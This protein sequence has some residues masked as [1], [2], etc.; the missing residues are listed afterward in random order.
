MSP[1][2]IKTELLVKPGQPSPNIR[3]SDGTAVPCKEVVKYLGSLI[4]W[5]RPF[6]I[7]YKRRTA[8][9]EEAY[10]KL[11]LVWNSSLGIKT[12][13]RIFQSIFLPVLLYG[14]DSFTLTTPQ[15]NRLDAYYY[16]FL[17]RIVGIKASYY[18]RVSNADVKDKAGYPNRP[19]DSLWKQQFQFMKG[20]F[21]MPRSEACHSVVF[22]SVHRDRVLAQGRRRAMQF[23]YWLEVSAKRYFPEEYKQDHYAL[24]QQFRY[25]EIAKQ[26]Q[27][28]D[29]GQAPKRA[30][31]RARP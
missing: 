2:H 17:R 29:F 24:G 4:S 30:D 8:L 23:P 3:F 9:A 31:T 18:S 7:A 20:V 28:P 15:L 13:L 26:L 11:Q 27:K 22:S 10:K 21:Q 14:M 5:N 16:P 12:K 6:H 19:S 25:A 1:N